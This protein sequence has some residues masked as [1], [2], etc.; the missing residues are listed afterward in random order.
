MLTLRVIPTLDELARDRHWRGKRHLPALARS[1]E[2]CSR[3]PVSLGDL[4][5][6][7]GDLCL[8][9]HGVVSQHERTREWP[10][11]ASEV[12]H[13]IRVRAN[14]H[15]RL[16]SQLPS[17]RS[18]SRLSRFDKPGERR[19]S[20]HRP[21]RLAAEQR[22]V[23]SIT[24]ENDHRRVCPRKMLDSVGL[25]AKG[26]ARISNDERAPAGCAPAG[27]RPPVVERHSSN[28]QACIKV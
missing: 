4:I 22:T 17:H 25:T 7:H 8:G 13:I 15:S 19:H 24:D 23:I 20:P 26:P 6:I 1:E 2:L 21:T 28:R 27:A 11:L 18:L 14:H 9:G 5:A 16:L 3:V 12:L 10:G